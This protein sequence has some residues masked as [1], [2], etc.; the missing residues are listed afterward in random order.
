M[1]IFK[2]YMKNLSFFSC[3]KIKRGSLMQVTAAFG[4]CLAARVVDILSSG[5]R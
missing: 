3:E 1:R 5:S 4:M 2:F